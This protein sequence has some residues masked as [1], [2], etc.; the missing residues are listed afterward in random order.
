MAIF[1]R[2]ARSL[3]NETILTS[4]AVRVPKDFKKAFFNL[5][6]EARYSRDS[7]SVVFILICSQ[8]SA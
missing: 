5:I 7:E 1:I 4:R 6:I 2:K 8:T 3:S